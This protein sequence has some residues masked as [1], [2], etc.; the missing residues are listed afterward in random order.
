MVLGGL[1]AGLQHRLALE[2]L[3]EPAAHAHQVVMVA[4]VVPS[5]ELKAAPTLG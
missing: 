1:F 2:F 4:M 3:G 5:G